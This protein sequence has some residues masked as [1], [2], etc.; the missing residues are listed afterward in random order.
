[1]IHR[2]EIHACQLHEGHPD[3][4]PSGSV[5]LDECTR[6][7]DCTAKVFGFCGKVLDLHPRNSCF[8][9]CIVDSDCAAGEICVCG[10]DPV[11]SLSSPA[12]FGTCR[13]AD[14]T[15]DSDCLPGFHC[16]TYD[17][18]PAC[19]SFAFSCQ[20]PADDCGGNGDCDGQYCTI[21]A[22]AP[23]GGESAPRRCVE[24]TCA[25]WLP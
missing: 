6:D 22:V 2:R 7:A 12:P 13:R 20:V 17:T 8:Y 11:P 25:L 19:F 23:A 1:M 15:S 10:M 14:C 18:T 21:E 4:G 3:P 24:P 9:G 16:A 5:E